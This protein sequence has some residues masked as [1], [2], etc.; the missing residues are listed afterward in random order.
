MKWSDYFDIEVD[1][2]KGDWR[3]VKIFLKEK[4]TGKIIAEYKDIKYATK[5][6]KHKFKRLIKKIERTVLG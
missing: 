6:A 4:S 5:Q 1:N 3:D 2:S